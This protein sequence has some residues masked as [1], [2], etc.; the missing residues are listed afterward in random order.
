[1]IKQWFNECLLLGPKF[2]RRERHLNPNPQT[3]IRLIP[4]RPTTIINLLEV[5]SLLGVRLVIFPF[6]FTNILL[7]S[8]V[9]PKEHQSNINY[10]VVI[11]NLLKVHSRYFSE[12]DLLLTFHS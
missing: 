5:R 2:P 9:R 10:Q 4:N 11:A 1:M 3:T 6:D 7:G 8:K 12:H